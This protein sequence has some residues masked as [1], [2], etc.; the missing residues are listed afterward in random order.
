MDPELFQAIESPEFAAELNVVSGFRQFQRALA[1]APHVRLLAD[2]AKDPTKAAEV[3]ERIRMLAQARCDPAS[4]HPHDVALA[5]YLWTLNLVQPL[6]ASAVAPL[7]RRCEGS[8][9]ARKAAEAVA[10]QGVEVLGRKEETLAGHA[11]DC[12]GYAVID[13]PAEAVASS[14]AVIRYLIGRLADEGRLPVDQ[15]SRAICQVVTRERQG[16]TVLATGIAVP[17]SKSE[18]AKP[19]GIIGRSSVPILWEPSNDVPVHEVCLLLLPVSDPRE[20][21]RALK[22]A[23]DILSQSQPLQ[24]VG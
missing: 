17:H 21:L 15:T 13:L 18:V 8:W 11:S 23:T 24:T 22:E 7:V 4:E 19:V 14:D 9:W 16:S 2:K 3:V 12:L 10:A 5:T 20:S 1:S 6:V